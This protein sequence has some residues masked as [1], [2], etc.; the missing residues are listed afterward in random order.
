MLVYLVFKVDSFF[1][2]CAQLTTL[3][4]EHDQKGD[5]ATAEQTKTL[6]DKTLKHCKKKTF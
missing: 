2:D 5:S 1:S 6:N 3:W 4:H